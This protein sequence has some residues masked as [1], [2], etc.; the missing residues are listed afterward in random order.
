MSQI[1]WDWQRRVQIDRELSYNEAKRHWESFSEAHQ[2]AFREQEE[3]V[4]DWI[5]SQPDYVEP[6]FSW[7]WE[8]K[9]RVIQSLWNWL[10]GVR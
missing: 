1:P 4:R 8:F 3:R 10:R 9:T 6:H 7:W 5:L 2:K